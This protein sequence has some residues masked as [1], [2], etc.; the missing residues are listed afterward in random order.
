MPNAIDQRCA[1]VFASVLLERI[2]RAHR[3]QRVD[4]EVRT[5]GAPRYSEMRYLRQVIPDFFRGSRLGGGHADSDGTGVAQVDAGEILRNI[6]HDDAR[7]LC[8]WVQEGETDCVLAEHPSGERLQPFLR[9]S[10]VQG[11]CRGGQEAGNGPR[12]LPNTQQQD[13]LLADRGGR[14]VEHRDDLEP[15]VRW[16]YIA[17]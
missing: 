6:G 3:G 10:W 2:D 12:T 4:R 7:R 5:I 9:G 1:R 11:S 13:R 15:G 17:T 16:R 8:G 14:R